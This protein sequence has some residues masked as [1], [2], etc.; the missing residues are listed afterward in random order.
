MERGFVLLYLVSMFLELVGAISWVVDGLARQNV[1]RNFSAG[2]W[3]FLFFE[4]ARER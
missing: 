2:L 3:G 4:L 1:F